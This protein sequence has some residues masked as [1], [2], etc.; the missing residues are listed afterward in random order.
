MD[1]NI[2]DSVRYLNDV[3]GG[4]I[5]KIIDNKLVEICDEN[6]FEMPVLAAE[7]VLTG[8]AEKQKPS[9][10]AASKNHAEEALPEVVIETPI[11]TDDIE[12]NDTPQ[13]YLAFVP[14]AGNVLADKYEVYL[15]NDCNYHFIYTIQEKTVNALSLADAGLAD[16][17]T[18]ILVQKTSK[19]KLSLLSTYRIQGCYYKKNQN[20]SIPPVDFELKFNPVKFSKPGSFKENEFFEHQA[21]IFPIEKDKM[22]AAVEQIEETTLGA[23][24]KQ[25]H[26]KRPRVETKKKKVTEDIREIDLHIHEL[27][28]DETGLSAGDM[29]DIQIQHFKQEMEKAIIDRI[30]KVVFIH[31]VGQGVLKMKV[32]SILDR[33]YKKYQY[34]DASFAKYKFGATM[35]D[36]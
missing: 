15:I 17:N 25:E 21:L 35:V 6:G 29:L 1:F 12:G 30:K 11:V 2:G 31:G 8:K 7:L 3:G 18:K 28:E 34:Q 26:K 13:L 33:D 22:E 16:A 24:L 5:T 32:R 4:V 14:E 9:S 23:L 10:T 36:L 27:V 20:G 19:S